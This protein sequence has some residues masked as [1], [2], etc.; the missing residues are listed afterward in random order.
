MHHG[1]CQDSEMMRWALEQNWAAAKRLGRP[2]NGV[3]HNNKFWIL[4]QGK[5]EAHEAHCND[6]TKPNTRLLL[7]RDTF[8]NLHGHYSLKD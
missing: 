2:M 3:H 7:Q 1:L 6:R 5:P 8:L 4:L